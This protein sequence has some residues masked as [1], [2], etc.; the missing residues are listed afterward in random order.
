MSTPVIEVRGGGVAL[1]GRPILRD[2]DL[3]VAAGEVVALLG[4]NGSGKTTLVRTLLGLLPVSHGDVRLYGAPLADFGDWSRIGYVPQHSTI[5]QGVPST[6][7]EVVAAGRLARRR[8]FRPATRADREAVREALET[9]GLTDRAGQQVTAL[10]GGQQQRV[11]IAR[12]LAGDPDLLFLDE[13]NAG[14]DL[15]SQ[16]AIAETLTQRARSGSTMVVV[17]HELGPLASLV[18]RTVVL[19]EGRIIYDG[20]ASG[21]PVSDG[22]VHCAEEPGSSAFPITGILGEV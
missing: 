10:S 8:P 20:P 7:R 17:L 18:Q 15:V 14:V 5:T 16:E 12:T 1:S 6:V 21:M 9:V 19:R 4:A 2:I 11:L 22:H 13:P 3:T